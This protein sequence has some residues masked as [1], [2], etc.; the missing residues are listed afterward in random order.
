MTV[1]YAGEMTPSAVEGT[2][3]AEGLAVTPSREQYTIQCVITVTRMNT[4]IVAARTRAYELLGC[5]GQ[6]LVLN[7]TLGGLVMSA[8]IAAVTLTQSQGTSGAGA[9]VMFGVEVDA[10]SGR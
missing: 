6:V 1:G 3:V 2:L 10:Y 7:H 4:D 8:R 5:V 9:A